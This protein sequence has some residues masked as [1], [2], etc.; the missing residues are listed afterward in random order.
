L[1]RQGVDPNRESHFGLGQKGGRAIVLEFDMSPDEAGIVPGPFLYPPFRHCTT[2]TKP[3]VKRLINR[4]TIAAGD[5]VLGKQL[6][7]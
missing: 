4:T 1:K 7:A 5:V 2:G 3:G 6:D